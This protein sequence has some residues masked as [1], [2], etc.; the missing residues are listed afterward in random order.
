VDKI[1]I[2]ACDDSREVLQ[3]I[4]DRILKE[5]DMDIIDSAS[6]G[7]ECLEKIATISKINVLILDLI[8]PNCDGFGVLREI[9]ARYHQNINKIIVI[10]AL[11]NPNIV[12]YIS[13]LGADLFIVKPFDV[14]ALIN[15]IRDINKNM[16]KE[17]IHNDNSLYLFDEAEDTENVKIAKIRLENDI[18]SLLHE[19]GIPAHIKGYMYLRSAIIETYNNIDLL[20]QITKMLYPRI[21][22]QY[23][24]TASR[25]ERAIRH[26]IEV[27]WNR[28]NIDVI[29]SIF[30]YTISASKAKP[31]N[32]EFIAMLAD[33]LILQHRSID[34]KKQNSR[35]HA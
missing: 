35:I 20:G 9:K 3:M 23:N 8:M 11:V 29:D 32:S 6:D 10:S 14:N 33:R 21:A 19:I 17:A 25:V 30:G 22:M 24:T 4:K 34:N 27:A 26:A 28:G 18:T 5:N 31:T 1:K 13:D 2:F 16:S 7:K 12:S 15:M